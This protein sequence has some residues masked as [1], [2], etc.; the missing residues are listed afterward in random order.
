ML[1]VMLSDIVYDLFQ[2]FYFTLRSLEKVYFS[3]FLN[4]FMWIFIVERE[5]QPTFTRAPGTFLLTFYS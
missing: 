4:I 1:G 3:T 2:C 5:K